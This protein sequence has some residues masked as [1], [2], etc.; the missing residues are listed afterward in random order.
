M[1]RCFRNWLA[2]IGCMLSLAGCQRTDAIAHYSVPHVDETVPAP[3]DNGPD[4]MLAAIVP[5][6]EAGWFFKL[7]GEKQAVAALADDFV[8]LVKTVHFDAKTG[9]ADWEAPSDWQRKPASE[10][11]F[12]TLVIPAESGKL[13]LSVIKLPKPEGEDRIYYLANINRWRGQ[14]K[15]RPV[16]PEQMDSLMASLALPNDQSAVMV[17][18]VGTSGAGGMGAGGMA[19]P[20]ASKAGGMPAGHPPVNVGEKTTSAERPSNSPPPATSDRMLAAALLK[21]ESAWF[22]K[23]TGPDEAVAAQQDR[24]MKMIESIHFAK[25]G[26]PQWTTPDGWR[27][28]A[29]SGMRFA[30]LIVDAERKLEVSITSLGKPPQIDEQS[31]LLDNINRWRGQMSLKKTTA[32]RLTD[33]AQTLKTADGTTATVVN[34]RGTAAAGG[35]GGP[36]FGGAGPTKAATRSGAN[37][38]Q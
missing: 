19:A 6:E 5:H 10:T 7:Q 34:L 31:Y 29:G 33:D 37:D 24:F 12:A 23:L 20:V 2:L 17:N 38:G 3:D 28:Q 18:L 15:L 16:G 27:Q 30:T 21:D 4:R 8:A 22:F 9:D 26:D 36:M 13:E 11:R 25:N 1:P 32:Q 35:M 14:M